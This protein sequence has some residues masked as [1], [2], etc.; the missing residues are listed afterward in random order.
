MAFRNPLYTTPAIANITREYI[1]S[2]TWTKPDGLKELFVLCV[3]A[4][5]GGGGGARNNGSPGGGGGGGGA[6]IWRRID[7]SELDTTETITIGAGG[8]GGN[9][10]TGSNGNGIAGSAGGDTIFGTTPK[11]R[12]DGG[13]G[14]A[15]GIGGGAA[16][17]GGIGGTVSNSLPN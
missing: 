10:R 4:G 13:A 15:A 14:G 1:S 8:N 5:G 17:A 9:G 11:V 7:A 16:S 12:A 2:D 3:G 6:L